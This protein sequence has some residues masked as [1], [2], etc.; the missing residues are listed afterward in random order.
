MLDKPLALLTRALNGLAAALFIV[1]TA[2]VCLQVFYRYVLNSPLT[3]SEEAARAILIY[4]VLLG[5]AVAVG[6]RSHMAIDYFCNRFPAPLRKLA[7]LLYLLAIAAI[8]LLFM[9]KGSELAQ[10]TMMQTT[11]ALQIPKGLIVCAFPLGGALMLL[12]ALAAVLP[13]TCTGKEPSASLKQEYLS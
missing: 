11:P 4:I 13:R 1:M 9:V 3:G 8:A 2:L 10:R 7:S 5:S 6:N 12:Y